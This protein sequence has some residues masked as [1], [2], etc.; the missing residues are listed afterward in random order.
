MQDVRQAA[1]I[2]L[3]MCNIISK[4]LRV[5]YWPTGSN[6]S[7]VL[8]K[9]LKPALVYSSCAHQLHTKHDVKQKDVFPCVHVFTHTQMVKQSFL[10]IFNL[11]DVFPK[12][13]WSKN[14]SA[15]V[16]PWRCGQGHIFPCKSKWSWTGRGNASSP[17]LIDAR[18]HPIPLAQFL[19]TLVVANFISALTECNLVK[20]RAPY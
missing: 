17:E 15:N 6:I 18:C 16:A 2:I 11:K 8:L 4:C 12:N 3:L 7:R 5:Y 14:Q 13:K 19:H 10:G 1:C 20:I 9:C